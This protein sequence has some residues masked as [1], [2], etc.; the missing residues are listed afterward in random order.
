MAVKAARDGGDGLF[1]HGSDTGE[2]P[3]CLTRIS[4]IGGNFN[5]CRGATMESSLAQC[6][7]F[8]VHMVKCPEGTMESGVP[9]ARMNL[10]AGFFQPLRS[11]LICVGRFATWTRFWLERL[12]QAVTRSAVKWCLIYTLDNVWVR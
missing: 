11:W 12:I 9:S 8:V 5:S 1:S 2:T 3:F 7:G 10:S 6:A 4:R